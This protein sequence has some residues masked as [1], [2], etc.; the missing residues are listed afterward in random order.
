LCSTH[1]E[2]SRDRRREQKSPSASV[3]V[4]QQPKIE[5]SL[6]CGTSNG[7]AAAGDVLSDKKGVSRAPQM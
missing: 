7:G 2:K 4:V 3:I 1:E 5:M 6:R